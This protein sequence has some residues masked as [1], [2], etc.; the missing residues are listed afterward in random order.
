[1]SVAAIPSP[2]SRQKRLY[3]GQDVDLGYEPGAFDTTRQ[4]KRSRLQRSP[5]ATGRCGLLYSVT[6]QQGH[7]S[8]QTA[9]AALQA[10]FPGMDD[11]VVQD[12]L[13]EC[14]N[15]ID[16][17]IKRLTDL[18]LSTED[19]TVAAA[20]AAASAELGQQGA[21]SSTQGQQASPQAGSSGTAATNP[22]EPQTAEQWIE[23]LVSEMLAS[24]DMTDARTRA[25]HVLQHFERFVKQ[26]H[27]DESDVKIAELMKENTIFKRAVQIQAQRMQ[28]KTSTDAD[29]VHQL[30][31]TLSQYQEQCRK[32]EMHNYSLAMHLQQ[33]TSSSGMG[34]HPRNPDVY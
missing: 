24:K 12:V 14:G 33:A 4:H 7:G 22:G 17:A 8:H 25:A 29:E 31:A 3:E 2:A 15:S 23:Y 9:V 10:L 1:M 18:R 16:A 30:R 6:D 19:A 11:K 34:S 5:S 32:L 27:K 26:R 21:G 20:T 13:V 28:A